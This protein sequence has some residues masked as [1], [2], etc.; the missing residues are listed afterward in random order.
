MRKLIALKTNKESSGDY[1]PFVVVYTDYSA[2]RATPLEQE[3]YLCGNDQEAFALF[4]KYSALAESARA[5]YVERCGPLRQM[6][7]AADDRFTWVD[8]PWPWEG[9][10]GQEVEC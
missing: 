4:Q 1:A 2:G 3:I 9:Q 10:A 7:V 5:A 6:D 8:G